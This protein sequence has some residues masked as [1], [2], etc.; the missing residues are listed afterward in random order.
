MKILCHISNIISI[1]KIQIVHNNYQYALAIITLPAAVT[2]Q[3]SIKM[4]FK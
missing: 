3:K 1:S 4:L 2:Y